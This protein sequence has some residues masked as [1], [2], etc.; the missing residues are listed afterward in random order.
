M[1]RDLDGPNCVRPIW[2]EFDLI[3]DGRRLAAA[4]VGLKRSRHEPAGRERIVTDEA[5]ALDG[6]WVEF[7]LDVQADGGHI[8]PSEQRLAQFT[9]H[10]T[11][12][13]RA[14]EFRIAGPPAGLCQFFER[15]IIDFIRP[16]VND[17]ERDTCGRHFSQQL[18]GLG[19]R[20]RIEPHHTA[21]QENESALPGVLASDLSGDRQSSG[22]V[23]QATRFNRFQ[24]SDSAL[25]LFTMGGFRQHSRPIRDHHERNLV[26]WPKL[27]GQ[28][29]QRTPQGSPSLAR[30][31][32]GGR[33]DRQRKTCG[34]VF[35]PIETT[36]LHANLQ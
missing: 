14:T 16:H 20:C 31:H 11:G 13:G 22:E 1:P 25:Q 26:L 18:C 33:I 4:E 36:R 12:H 15:R 28:V 32:R 19:D 35:G 29:G 27:I 8:R 3:E 2:F 5:I 9:S 24:L 21:R 10:R 23:G 17:P 7:D 34:A 6:L 30:S